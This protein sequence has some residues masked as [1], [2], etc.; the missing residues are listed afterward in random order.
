[1]RCSEFQRWISDGLA[2]ALPEEK[3]KRLDE[4]LRRCPS[5]RSFERAARLIQ[6]EAPRLAEDAAPEE[7]WAAGL[8]RL[9]RRLS[10]EAVRSGRESRRGPLWKWAFAAA[11]LVLA[12]AAGLFL[13]FRPA[14]QMEALLPIAADERL[15]D[16]SFEIADNPE[17]MNAFNQVLE[18]TLGEELGV[19]AS[20]RS[21]G[22]DNPILYQEVTDEELAFVLEELKKEL[23]S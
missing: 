18:S 23:R 4:H 22:F 3:R 17:L 2:G 11:P 12:A 15:G 13:L 9:K 20:A 8:D 10:A 6:E 1:M 7:S 16:L 19:D 21:G 14:G 5:C